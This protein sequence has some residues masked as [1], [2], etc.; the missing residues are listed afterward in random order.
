ME[1]EVCGCVE[2][3][4]NK[5]QA[6]GEPCEQCPVPGGV[7]KG[8]KAL[9]YPQ[10]NFWGNSKEPWVFYECQSNKCKGGAN[11]SCHPGFSGHLCE[12]TATGYASFGNGLRLTCPSSEVGR[13]LQASLWFQV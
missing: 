7:C 2:G 9:P 3:A 10:E 13:W 1:D 11:F 12:G 5:N 4:Y 8:A 6:T